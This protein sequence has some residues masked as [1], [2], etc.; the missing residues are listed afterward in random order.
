MTLV[1]A[2]VIGLFG[3]GLLGLS[4][5]RLARAKTLSALLQ[6]LGACCLIIVV[7]THIAEALRIWPSMGWGEPHSVGHYVD[8]LSALVGVALLITASAVWVLRR[9][10]LN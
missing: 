6:L 9:A 4:V 7:L 3:A 10:H 2:L 1:K 5:V 8:L